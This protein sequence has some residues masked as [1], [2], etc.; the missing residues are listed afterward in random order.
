MAS[1]KP[2]AVLI[3]HGA[4]FLPSAW[5]N[6]GNHLTQAGLT[7]R[8]PHLPSCNDSQPP[9]SLLKDDLHAVRAAAK[10]LIASNHKIIVLAHSYGGIVAS[11][12]ITPDLYSDRL[13]GS[14]VVSLIYLSAWLIVPG[15]SLQDIFARHG[16]QSEVDLGMHS[17]EVVFAKNAPES[18]YNDIERGEAEELAKKNVTHHWTVAMG[19]IGH[20]PWR[21]L[22]LAYV[23]CLRD[24]AILGPLQKAMV[25][26][27][28]DAGGDGIVTDSI[29]SGHCPF[30]SKPG[31][32][33]RII[34]GIVSTVTK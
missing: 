27:A 8:C 14:G 12:A 3:I 20:A 23:F 2:V 24:K 25:K 17:D 29:D 11:E 34:E 32:F 28:V 30:L 19:K 7:V 13:G 26:D 21:D 1:E 10:D 33:Q 16:A 5:K 9:T 6:F 4:Y 31:K 15:E 22:P 18:F